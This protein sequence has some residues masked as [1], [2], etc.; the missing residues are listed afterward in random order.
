MNYKI[1]EE[2]LTGIADAIRSKTGKTEEI[3]AASFA[4]NINSIDTSKPEETKEV[5]LD[6]SGGDMEVVPTTGNV[7][8]KVTIPQPENLLPGNIAEGVNVAGIVGVLAASGGGSSDIGAEKYFEKRYAEVDLPNVESIKPYAFRSDEVLTN[9][10]MPKVKSIGEYAF[11]G[12]KNL[13][14]TSLPSGLTYIGGNAFYNCTKLALISLP[15]GLTEIESS[16]FANC[17]NLALTSLPSS[18]TK[19]NSETFSGCTN[20]AL[21]SLPSGITEISSNAF[22]NCTKLAL[23]SLPSGLKSIGSNAFKNCTGLTSLTF[24]GK[25]TSI[26]NTA[27]NACTN[28]TTINVPWAEGQVS[29]APWGA[30]NATINYNYTGG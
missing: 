8:S 23:T 26:T 9:I 14:L 10:S 28:L 27:F 19:I 6:F 2:T 22:Y 25:P 12:C 29:R 5:L 20:L 30:T 16:A 7:I 18:I 4:D 17:K 1:K 21:T 15:S 3:L 24:E 13:A 11:S